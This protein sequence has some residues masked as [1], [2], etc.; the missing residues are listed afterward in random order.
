M[1]NDRGEIVDLYVEPHL[2]PSTL[3]IAL[4]AFGLDG[5]VG[6]AVMKH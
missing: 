6:D 5:N 3:V 1:E 2:C 4:V